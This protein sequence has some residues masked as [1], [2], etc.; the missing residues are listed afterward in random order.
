M[1]RGEIE[2][3]EGRCGGSKKGWRGGE[4]GRRG[5]EGGRRGEGCEGLGTSPYVKGVRQRPTQTRS[6][7]WQNRLEHRL[8]VCSN[9]PVGTRY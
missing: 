6:Q 9:P 5:G 7:K 2:K 1:R 4:G 3:S 8:K